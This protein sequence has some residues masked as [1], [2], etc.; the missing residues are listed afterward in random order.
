MMKMV[1]QHGTDEQTAE[2]AVS[3]VTSR[4]HAVHKS[5]SRVLLGG[6]P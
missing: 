4:V 2:V 5:D 1:L 6:A 3:A